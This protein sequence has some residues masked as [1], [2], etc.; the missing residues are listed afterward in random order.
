VKKGPALA[1]PFSFAVRRLNI[2]GKRPFGAH[3]SWRFW[4]LVDGRPVEPTGLSEFI[5]E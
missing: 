5:E 3:F 4:T 1:G 2:A